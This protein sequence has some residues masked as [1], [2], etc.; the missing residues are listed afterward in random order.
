MSRRNDW[1]KVC[2]CGRSYSHDEWH[3]LK[4]LPVWDIGLE[5]R[6]DLRNCECN[7]TMAIKVY[8]DGSEV[9]SDSPDT[10]NAT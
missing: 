1:P 9:T 7:S 6:L 8:E 4:V 2:A 3:E 10:E 5:Y